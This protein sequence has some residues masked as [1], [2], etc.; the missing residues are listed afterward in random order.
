MP[1]T[2]KLSIDK[3]TNIYIELDTSAGQEYY[4]PGVT[5]T[6]AV[7]QLEATIRELPKE[8][9]EQMFESIAAFAREM[10]SKFEQEF[11]KNTPEISIEYGVSLLGEA[12]IETVIFGPKGAGA[13]SYEEWVDIQSVFDTAAILAET[14]S[15][16]CG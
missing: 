8:V 3:N 14:A 10:L 13:H 2:R 5:E 4:Q 15:Q 1:E 11:P 7:S 16:F 9:L 6:G 12:G